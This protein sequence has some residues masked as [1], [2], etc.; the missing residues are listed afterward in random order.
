MFSSMAFFLE[1][2]TDHG[3][4]R[5]VVQGTNLSDAMAKAKSALQ[6]VDCIRATLRHTTAPH[7]PF[8]EGSILA[9]YTVG[10]GWNISTAGPEKE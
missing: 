1:Y 6:G 9:A 10:E 2:T 4:G 7:S 8:G 5:C 3:A